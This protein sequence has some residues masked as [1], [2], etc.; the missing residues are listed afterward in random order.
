MN[1]AVDPGRKPKTPVSG[2]DRRT[3]ERF[4]DTLWM[5]RGLRD[6]TLAAYRADDGVYFTF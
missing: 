2:D 6:A 4:L 3:I 1:T 5:E